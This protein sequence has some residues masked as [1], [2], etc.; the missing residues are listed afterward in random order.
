MYVCILFLAIPES[1]TD[2][3]NPGRRANHQHDPDALPDR[4]GL[5]VAVM[6]RA[7]FV[8]EK[9]LHVHLLRNF[10]CLDGDSSLVGGIRLSRAFVP[11]LPYGVHHTS[12]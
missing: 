4:G 7:S 1:C 12:A 9:S 3:R 10:F 5:V 11:G 2:A 6:F 8:F